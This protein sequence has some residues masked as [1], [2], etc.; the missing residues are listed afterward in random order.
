MAR[1][2]KTWKMKQVE[3]LMEQ[4]YKKHQE[5]DALFVVLWPKYPSVRLL[6]EHLELDKM[7]VHQWLRVMRLK[8]KKKTAHWLEPLP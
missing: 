8:P 3:K 6:A 1:F 4:R 2:Q 7:R 5:L